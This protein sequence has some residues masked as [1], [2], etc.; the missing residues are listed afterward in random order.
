MEEKLYRV[1]EA[2]NILGVSKV[3]IYKKLSKYKKELR[4]HVI[5]R[6]NITYLQEEAIN[7]IRESLIDNAVIVPNEGQSQEV[8]RLKQDQEIMHMNLAKVNDALL[9]VHTEHIEDLQWIVQVV[10]KQVQIK[11]R[12]NEQKKQMILKLKDLVKQA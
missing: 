3:T 12:Q 8:I 7:F 9:D 1:I 4:A 5:K 11:K 6:S 2:A 10:Q